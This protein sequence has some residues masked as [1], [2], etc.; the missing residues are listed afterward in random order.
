MTKN[1]SDVLSV[2]SNYLDE[3][4]F[5][6][7]VPPDINAI[8]LGFSGK[9]YK[10]DTIF[11][12][13]DTFVTYQV[14]LPFAIQEEKF[15]RLLRKANEFSIKNPVCGV[16]ILSNLGPISIKTGTRLGNELPS[17]EIIE[18]MMF[19]AFQLAEESVQDFFNILNS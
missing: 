18:A 12:V 14:R 4:K 2:I 19:S 3:R 17:F 7:T 8:V 9:V 1:A 11:I 5:A 6:Y 10:Y 16:E 15:D 13:G